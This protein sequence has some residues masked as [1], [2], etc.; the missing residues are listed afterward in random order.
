MRHPSRHPSLTADI[1][2]QS[3]SHRTTHHNK[4]PAAPGRFHQRSPRASPTSTR[5][6]HDH[7]KEQGLR[8]LLDQSCQLGAKSGV[9]TFHIH[10]KFDVPVIVTELDLCENNPI[11]RQDYSCR[12]ESDGG[13]QIEEFAVGYTWLRGT[14]TPN[15]SLPG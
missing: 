14:R 12:A 8:I 10:G 1:P 13:D 3:R 11:A 6:L 9:V 4:R 15:S 2:T 7:A 5:H